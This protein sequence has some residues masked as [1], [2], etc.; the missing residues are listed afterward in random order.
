[1][2][3]VCSV[4]ASNDVYVGRVMGATC[5]CLE[6]ASIALCRNYQLDLENSAISSELLTSGKCHNEQ[7][8]LRLQT[9]STVGNSLVSWG[10][11]K[12]PS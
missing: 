12:T 8:R 6:N 3:P 4:C 5:N 2:I 7:L 11:V 10:I 1:M 9:C